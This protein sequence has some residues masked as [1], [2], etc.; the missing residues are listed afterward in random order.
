MVYVDLNPIRAGLAGTPEESDCTSIQERIRAWQQETTATASVSREAPQDAP[1]GSF[2]SEKRRLES[3][4][5]LLNPIPEPMVI[6][7]R[8]FDGAVHPLRWLCPIASDSERRGIL[9]MT[10]AEY[11]DLV[12][13]SG[14]MLRPDKRGAI[15]AELA[16]ILLRI[17]ANPEAWLETISRFGFRF[18]LAA[19]L[20]SNLRDFAGLLGRQWFKGVGTARAAFA[21]SPPQLA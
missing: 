4:G 18:Q 12:D 15:D 6:M 14:R 17:G 7:G 21:S 19:G 11:F 16:P 1:S 8:S 2:G 20:L 3:A 5:E 10:T 9:E 13:K